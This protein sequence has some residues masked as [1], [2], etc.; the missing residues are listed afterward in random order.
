MSYDDDND[1]F[2]SSADSY[3]DETTLDEETV[4]DEEN[5]LS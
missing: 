5:D 3:L 2:E 1:D 4:S